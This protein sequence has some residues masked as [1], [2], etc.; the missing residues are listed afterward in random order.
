ME[1][2]KEALEKARK[3]FEKLRENFECY[4][5]Y[6]NY[7]NT[8]QDNIAIMAGKSRKQNKMTNKE[9]LQDLEQLYYAMTN[10]EVRDTASAKRIAELAL[11]PVIEELYNRDIKPKKK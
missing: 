11:G 6:D 2:S 10:G 9:I 8:E 5:K 3:A 1:V 4:R 7:L